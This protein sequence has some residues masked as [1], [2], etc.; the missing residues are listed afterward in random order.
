[1]TLKSKSNYLDHLDQLPLS[2]KGKD[3]R[4]TLMNKESFTLGI[5]EAKLGCHPM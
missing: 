3:V 4:Q 5:T 2:G 1:M